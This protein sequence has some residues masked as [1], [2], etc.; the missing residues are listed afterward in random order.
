MLELGYINGSIIE[1]FALPNNYDDGQTASRLAEK[2]ILFETEGQFIV[3]RTI[4]LLL[5]QLSEADKTIRVNDSKISVFKCPK[6]F[7]IL[8][9]DERSTQ[10]CR[11]TPIQNYECL[12]EYLDEHDLKLEVSDE[13]N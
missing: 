7:V 10:K 1:M 12:T 9:E 4:A 13:I 2:G 8:S 3:E 11:I 6:M 5:S